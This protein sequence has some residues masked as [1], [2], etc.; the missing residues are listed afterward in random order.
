MLFGTMAVYCTLA[1]PTRRRALP[2]WICGQ[3]LISWCFPIS[4]G[5]GEIS[6]ARITDKAHC[7]SCWDSRA[8][9]ARSQRVP[10]RVAVGSTTRATPALSILDSFEPHCMGYG[11]FDCLEA[12]GW[13][14][15]TTAGLKGP[16][17]TRL[18]PN[19]WPITDHSAD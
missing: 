12:T 5:V 16:K 6:L 19:L 11:A 15:G 14:S 8:T 17:S 7:M 10:S 2:H 13:T 9:S 18:I 4:G 1:A 3:R